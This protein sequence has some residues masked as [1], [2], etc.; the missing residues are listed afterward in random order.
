MNESFQLLYFTA[1]HV[2][3]LYA[4][5][6]AQIS[7]HSTFQRLVRRARWAYDAGTSATQVCSN[8]VNVWTCVEAITSGYVRYGVICEQMYCS[9]VLSAEAAR[10]CP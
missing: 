2:N 4:M 7:F 9:T 6:L 10:P 3:L 8:S 1:C 5:F